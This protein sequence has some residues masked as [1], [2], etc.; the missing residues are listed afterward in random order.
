MNR[1]EKEQEKQVR[2]YNKMNFKFINFLILERKI[3]CNKWW[4]RSIK[5]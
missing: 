2:S 1:W 4:D 5:V 3:R